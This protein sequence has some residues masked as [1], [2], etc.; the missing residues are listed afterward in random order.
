MLFSTFLDFPDFRIIFIS[1][2]TCTSLE[3]KLHFVTAGLFIWP[4][5]SYIQLATNLEECDVDERGVVVDELEAE[6]LHGV[7]VLEVGPRPRL[8]HVGQ[9]QRHV[10]VD[11]RIWVKF[12]K[13]AFLIKNVQKFMHANFSFTNS[14]NLL[15]NWNCWNGISRLSTVKI[16]VRETVDYGFAVSK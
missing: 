11:L 14:H 9:P 16:G 2:Q 4:L 15:G 3:A 8:L 6:E 10:T 12:D 7:A 5:P 13:I 1:D